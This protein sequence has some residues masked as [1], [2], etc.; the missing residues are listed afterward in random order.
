M[1]EKLKYVDPTKAFVVHPDITEAYL[2]YDGTPGSF[3]DVFK[4]R[5]ARVAAGED[6]HNPDHDIE[7]KQSALM[8][9]MNALMQGW[10]FPRRKKK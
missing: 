4:D 5:D 1:A 7:M 9:T 3:S 8:L 10:H 6:Y 2:N